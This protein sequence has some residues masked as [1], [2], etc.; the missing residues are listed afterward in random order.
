MASKRDSRSREPRFGPAIDA[1]AALDWMAATGGDQ[2]D[3]STDD[4]NFRPSDKVDA[5]SLVARLE[6]RFLPT[7]DDDVA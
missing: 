3:D 4:L 6:R 2:T 1:F 5:A 7:D